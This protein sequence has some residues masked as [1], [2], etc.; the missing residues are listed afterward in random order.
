V[1]PTVIAC[2][3]IFYMLDRLTKTGVICAADYHISIVRVSWEE[4]PCIVCLEMRAD[5]LVR[6]LISGELTN[7]RVLRTSKEPLH[8]YLL[9]A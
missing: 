2:M 3:T 8:E 9:C 1:Y 4:R 6:R 7:Y 5:E